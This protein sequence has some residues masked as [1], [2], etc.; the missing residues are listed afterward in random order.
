MASITEYSTQIEILDDLWVNYA[1][2]K[3]FE[4]LFEMYDVGLPLAHVIQNGIVVSTPLAREYVEATF[5]ALLKVCA[6]DDRGF[7]SLNQI[8]SEA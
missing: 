2:D 7:V 1:D 5:A 8:L 3:R 4:F 6:R